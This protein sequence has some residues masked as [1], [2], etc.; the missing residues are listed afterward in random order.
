MSAPVII[1]RVIGGSTET[2]IQL[3]NGQFGRPITLPTGWGTIRV[4]LRL[5]FTDS[6]AD[7]TGTPNFAVGFGNGTTNMVGDL[8]TNNW[9]GIMPTVSWARTSASPPFYNLGGGTVNPRLFT[10]IGTTFTSGSYMQAGFTYLSA[11]AGGPTPG[12]QLYFLDIQKGSPNYSGANFA[13]INGTIIDQSAAT[14]LT[15]MIN[16]A[17][18][19]SNYNY[20]GFDA[21]IAFSESTYPLNAVQIWWDRSD[22]LLEICD[23]AVAVLA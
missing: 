13:P 7:L 17:P 1:Q 22:S 6:G 10:K 15:L 3:N 21:A 23:L 2:A 12:R 11:S 20:S 18:S 14:F 9:I 19:L 8:T 4:G 5:H 16:S